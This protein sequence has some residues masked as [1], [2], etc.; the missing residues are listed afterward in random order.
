MLPKQ[1]RLKKY[2]DF[3]KLFKKGKSLKE[4][5]IAI[6]FNHNNLPLSRFAIIVST[7][8]SKKAVKRNR[9]KRQIREIV[10]LL[11]KEEKIKP[12]FDAAIIPDSKILGKEYKEIEKKIKLCLEKI[13]KTGCG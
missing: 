6:K 4:D 2:K 3:Q 10:R 8:V 12:G 5:F 11:L 13:G 1:N 9:I 7:K